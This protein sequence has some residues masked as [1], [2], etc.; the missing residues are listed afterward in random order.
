MLPRRQTSVP[1]R[2]NDRLIDQHV[3]MI[4]EYE[5]TTTLSIMTMEAGS[6][7]PLLRSVPSLGYR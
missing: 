6:L 3:P 4:C 2:L 5:I 7:L 1:D